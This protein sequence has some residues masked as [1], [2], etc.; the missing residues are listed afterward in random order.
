MVIFIISQQYKIKHVFFW[1]V[2]F[3]PKKTMLGQN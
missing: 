3:V 1:F 2:I